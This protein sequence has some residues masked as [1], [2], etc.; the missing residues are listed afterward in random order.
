MNLNF[1]PLTDIPT[2]ATIAINT[3][4]KK[5]RQAG[6]RV[7]NLS[8]GEPMIATPQVIIE[9]AKKAIQDDKTKYPPT[10]GIT[11]LRLA[12]TEWMNRKY[13][14][15]YDV[16]HTLVTCGGKFG[17]YILFQALVESG[18][19]VLIP[20][21]YWVSY[22]SMVAL[23]GGIPKIVKTSESD[24]WK[25]E[26]EELENLYTSKTKI[27]ILNNGSNPTG[28]LYTRE[29]LEKILEWCS[30]K[31][32]IVISDEVYSGLV[33]DGGEYNS[34]GSFG[35]L[36]NNVVVVQSCSKNFA[37]T[38]WRVGFVFAPVEI[39]R[40]LIKL[41]SQSITSTS[42]I[43]QWA[44][45]GAIENADQ[46][47]SEIRT[48]MQ[49]RRD[50]LVQARNKFFGRELYTPQSSLYAFWP[51]NSFGV[52]DAESV[53]FCER[54]LEEGNVAM[55]PGKAFGQDGYVRVSFGETT[56]ELEEAME[57]LRRY[58]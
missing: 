27:L 35:K 12:M 52:N 1:S 49:I 14:T 45:L 24:G 40:T 55:V 30:E 36:S 22:P 54:V 57:A 42:G 15:N 8:A 13:N 2:S 23:F 17:L 25:V 44:A 34:C 46:I 26:V 21:P 3:L 39:V 16:D 7:Y 37:M 51:I 48:E 11:P 4:A 43:S 47:V 29:E 10:A 41:Q 50:V 32:I 53:R 20:A 6:E 56:D 19:E 18:T 31:D 38:G 28:V 33:Y 5:K 58:L 9:A